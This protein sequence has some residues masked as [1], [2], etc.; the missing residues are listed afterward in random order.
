VKL[1]LLKVLNSGLLYYTKHVSTTP[2]QPRPPVTYTLASPT[3]CEIN[4]SID[5][6][7]KRYYANVYG[8]Q[9]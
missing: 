8:V 1:L 4:S 6:E 7:H 5:N 3:H 2:S 9:S